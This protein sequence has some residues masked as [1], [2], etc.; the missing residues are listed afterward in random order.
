MH[1]IE[2]AIV[3]AYG[4]PRHSDGM[5]RVNAANAEAGT[6]STVIDERAYVAAQT[7]AETSEPM[8]YAKRRLELVGLRERSTRRCTRH[9]VRHPVVPTHADGRG[10]LSGLGRNRNIAQ[11]RD[12]AT[13]D[14]ALFLE[15]R[16]GVQTGPWTE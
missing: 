12:R 3:T 7:R 2:T 5:T 4:G 6:A 8:E 1:A 13:V 11:V 15:E 9:P 16:P 10:T 14:L